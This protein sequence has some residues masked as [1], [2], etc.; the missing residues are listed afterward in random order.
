MHYLQAH[1]ICIHFPADQTA[2]FTNCIRIQ[3]VY[4]HTVCDDVYSPALSYN[5]LV[6][7]QRQIQ[8]VYIPSS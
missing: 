1:Y 7:L 3:L 2:E 6:L 8:Q 5:I 4:L